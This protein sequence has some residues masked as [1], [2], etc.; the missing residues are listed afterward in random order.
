MARASATEYDIA[1]EGKSAS[2]F[3][4]ELTRFQKWWKRKELKK[5]L[6]KSYLKEIQWKLTGKYATRRTEF[7]LFGSKASD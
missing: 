6:Y 2:T 4:H 3:E 5:R 7:G 1:V